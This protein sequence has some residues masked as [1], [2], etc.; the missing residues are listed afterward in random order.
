[1]TRRVAKDDAE[2]DV[3][4]LIFKGMRRYLAQRYLAGAAAS[5]LLLSAATA[6][7]APLKVEVEDAA[8]HH[9]ALQGAFKG[10]LSNSWEWLL[11]SKRSSKNIVGINA[12]GL[13]AAH[14]LTGLQSH[15]RSA[16]KAAKALVAAYDGGWRNRRPHTQDIEFLAAAGYVIDAAKWF[17]VLT[18]R[19][20]ASSYVDYV[21]RRRGGYRSLA[22]W[23]I[24]SAV[25]AAVAVGEVNY[26][27]ALLDRVITRRASWDV[28]SNGNSR[29][30]SR[31]SLLWALA[32]YKSRS[33]LDTRQQRFASA[34]LRSVMAAQTSRGA[35]L[36]GDGKSLSTQTTAYAVLGL[37]GWPTGQRSAKAGKRWLV[38]TASTDRKF[39][40]GGRI[41]ASHYKLDG[42]PTQRYIS[43]IQ[44]EVLQA[45]AR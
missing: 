3:K 11:G 17:R 1:M 26:A 39:V 2:K 7:A 45:L 4:V 16:L 20:T 38:S 32:S 5:L 37:A 33:S 42:K 14:R 40:A 8:D 43:E 44:S 13:L 30:L 25:R 9:L 35:W 6:N 34:L 36:S 21:I 41:W 22:G 28:A 27:R 10:G 23:D 12:H 24:A 19:W 15:E 31:A 18:S 29:M